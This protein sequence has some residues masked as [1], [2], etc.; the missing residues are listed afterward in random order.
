[1]SRS[2]LLLVIVACGGGGGSS[3]VEKCDDLVDV[4]CDRAVECVPSGG[5]HA[6]CVQE[7]QQ[8][9]SCGSAKRV[10]ATYDRCMSQLESNSCAVLFPTNPQSGSRE[11]ALP[12][13]CMSVI[14][15]ATSAREHSE[16]ARPGRAV[17]ELAKEAVDGPR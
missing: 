10:S 13:D 2:W 4:V 12:A 15:T 7:V 9:I 16:L 14:L 17:T 1:M 6:A 5:T 11:L 8:V 3:A